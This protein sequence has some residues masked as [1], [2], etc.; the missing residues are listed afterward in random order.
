MLNRSREEEKRREEKRREEK[1][2]EE[3]RR[4]RRSAGKDELRRHK[5][6]CSTAQ[7]LNCSKP[8]FAE[9]GKWIF[10]ISLLLLLLLVLLVLFCVRGDLCVRLFDDLVCSQP[11]L[12]KP[13]AFES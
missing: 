1:R 11:G 9:A 7:L 12:V 4:A 5:S 3:K 2:R 6:I 10:I 8:S 13:T